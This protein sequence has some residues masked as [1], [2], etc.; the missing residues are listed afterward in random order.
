MKLRWFKRA[1][2]TPR[3]GSY[4]DSLYDD[5]KTAQFQ[6]GQFVSGD[7]SLADFF[8]KG[9]M[10][11]GETVAITPG[12]WD[13]EPTA[14]SYHYA[15]CTRVLVKDAVTRPATWR[16]FW[17]RLRDRPYWETRRYWFSLGHLRMLRLEP[18]IVEQAVVEDKVLATSET[19]KFDLGA[20]PHAVVDTE[21]FVKLTARGPE[22]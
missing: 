10:E 1:T 20:V 9:Q 18:V 11:V 21:I 14:M 17:D 4:H 2:P 6:D 19:G 15:L 16:D 8:G 5:G 13:G 12:F 22:T 7:P 3:V